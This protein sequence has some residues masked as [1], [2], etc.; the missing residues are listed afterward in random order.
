MA[1]ACRLE[2]NAQHLATGSERVQII[3]VATS[4]GGGGKTTIAVGLAAQFA[5]DG[6]NCL[7]IDF[8]PQASA[9]LSLGITPFE[10][11]SVSRWMLGDGVN[12]TEMA[13]KIGDNFSLLAGHESVMHA[14]AEFEAAVNEAGSTDE[15]I[16]IMTQLG[17]LIQES[18]AYDVVVLDTPADTILREACALAAVVIV[19][20]VPPARADME[21]FSLFVG[22]IGSLFEMVGYS[23]PVAVVANKVDDRHR[24]GREQLHEMIDEIENAGDGFCFAGTLHQSV[25][26]TNSFGGKP[27]PLQERNRRNRRAR[28]EFQ[29]LG[30][31]IMQQ[32]GGENE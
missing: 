32:A 8:D 11:R 25:E 16:A 26:I 6:Q 28:A 31:A 21:G 20:P 7:L 14:R 3:T 30:E 15:Q 22:Q 10:A 9:T 13:I 4:K 29:Q 23:I 12:I 19:S 17:K 2:S 24:Q 18:T 1:I 27:I 5:R